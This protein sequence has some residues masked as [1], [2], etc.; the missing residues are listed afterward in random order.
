MNTIYILVSVYLVFQLVV[1]R[2]RGVS[3][4]WFLRIVD[5]LLLFFMLGAMWFAFEINQQFAP[6]KITKT[7]NGRIVSE[8]FT[9]NPAYVEFETV[10]FPSTNGLEFR[11]VPHTNY[12]W[13]V[14]K[15]F[16]K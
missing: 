12:Y 16:Q 8:F 7:L 1:I 9:T 14:W 10:E 13:H 3:E 2:W 4:F 15:M 11:Q 6:H 5:F